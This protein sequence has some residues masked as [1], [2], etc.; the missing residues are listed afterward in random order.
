MEN[1]NEDHTMDDQIV[2]LHD[3]ALADKSTLEEFKLLM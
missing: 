1:F 3:V 2:A